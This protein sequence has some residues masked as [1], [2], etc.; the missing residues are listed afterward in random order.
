MLT[1]NHEKEPLQVYTKEYQN[2]GQNSDSHTN[3]IPR[4]ENNIQEAHIATI[5]IIISTILL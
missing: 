5:R 1:S 4:N 3:E 2:L